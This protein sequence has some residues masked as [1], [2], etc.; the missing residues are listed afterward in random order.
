PLSARKCRRRFVGVDE[1]LS[2]I[3]KFFKRW[4]TGAP[5]VRFEHP[6]L[7]TGVLI[8]SYWEMETSVQGKSFSLRVETE[9]SERPTAAQVNF[10]VRFSNDPE[11]AFRLARTRLIPRYE[12][13]IDAP[14]PESWNMAFEFVGMT[15][16]LL[17]S[18]QYPWD[19]QFDCLTDSSGHLFTCYF[20]NGE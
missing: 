11:L 1:V 4:V 20:E 13:W 8:D 9:G 19:L 2:M 5:P 7:G 10:F 3:I 18:E 15:V 14:F 17:G 12:Q 6:V 16:P